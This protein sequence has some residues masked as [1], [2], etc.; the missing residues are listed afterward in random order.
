MGDLILPSSGID[1][2]E[3]IKYKI[4]SLLNQDMDDRSLGTVRQDKLEFLL[5]PLA[6]FVVQLD[7]LT[8]RNKQAL[9]YRCFVHVEQFILTISQFKYTKTIQ[10]EKWE[11]LLLDKKIVILN[12][13][14]DQYEAAT[15][16]EFKDS[17]FRE[18]LAERLSEVKQLRTLYI[19]VCEYEPTQYRPDTKLLA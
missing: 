11:Q 5:K 17:R 14:V 18:A 15:Q 7:E 19:S 2:F 10:S 13:F 6:Q 4:A 8:F 1:L 12:Y 3:G 9:S 16:Q